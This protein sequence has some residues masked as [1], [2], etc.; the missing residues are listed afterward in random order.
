M[1]I[2]SPEKPWFPQW[3]VSASCT[4]CSER[5]MVHLFLVIQAWFSESKG[6]TKFHLYP[7][8][9]K[10]VEKSIITSPHAYQDLRV[11]TS[12]GLFVSLDIPSLGFFLY[13]Y[14]Y[15]L[16]KHIHSFHYS[17]IAYNI[18]SLKTGVCIPWESYLLL[19]SPI[20]WG[21]DL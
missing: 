15:Q 14:S 5:S 7:K 1:N 8:W 4:N 17:L 3:W 16:Y 21:Y 6:L 11:V 12:L 20:K 10:K 18:K 2:P 13:P 9:Q 19:S